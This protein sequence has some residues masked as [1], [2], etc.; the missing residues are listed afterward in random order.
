V[1]VDSEGWWRSGS[2]GTGSLV[3]LPARRLL[4][5]PTDG[6]ALPA[7]ASRT[8]DV[9]GR[10]ESAD[11]LHGVAAALLSVTVVRPTTGGYLTLRLPADTGTPRTSSI[12]FVAGRTTTNFV[13]APVDD[14]GQIAIY[15]GSGGST[16]VTVDMLGYVSR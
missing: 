10:P 12:N 16:N 6:G 15:N 5:T 2:G 9:T 11:H 14:A 13:V 3:G 8:V 4:D 1:I 7:R